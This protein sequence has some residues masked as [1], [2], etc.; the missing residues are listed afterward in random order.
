MKFMFSKGRILG[1]KPFLVVSRN[2][3]VLN[4]LVLYCAVYLYFFWY[5]LSHS[6]NLHQRL[7]KVTGLDAVCNILFISILCSLK[8]INRSF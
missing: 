3:G 5:S 6:G 4:A 1:E 7:F 8:S 2:Q